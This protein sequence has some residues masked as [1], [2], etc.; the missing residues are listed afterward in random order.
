MFRMCVVLLV[1]S[2]ICTVVV[3]AP[4]A[5]TGYSGE[6]VDI[7]CTYE[8]G[9][10][11][12]PKYLCKDACIYGNRI[13]M[14]KSGSPAKDQRFSLSDDRTARV[15]TVTITELRTADAGQYWCGVEK[16][17]I[18]DVY[19]EI[20]LLVKQDNKTT[21]V[22][23][24]STFTATPSNFSTT[25]PYPQSSNI[26]VTERKETITE[27]KE[28]ITER[29]ETIPDRHNSSAG[30]V[31]YISVGV[32]IMLVI[33]LMA[34]MLLCMKRSRKSPR[35]TQSGLSQ[36]VSVVLLPLNEK[37]AED[38][39][40]H[41]YEEINKWQHK[42]KDITTVYTTADRLDDPTI[43]STA[44]KPDD[45]TIYSTADKPD[46]STIYSSADKPEDSTI[47]STA[48]KPDDSMIYSTADKPDVSTIYSTVD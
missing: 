6:R 5:V 4:V 32:V 25:E 31:I 39:N 1:F 30:S 23:T 14:V 42:N 41:K 13:I 36:Q 19:S 29:N 20:L 28:T 48:D 15:F 38:F 11:S 34:L 43:Y 18:D 24:I 40:D 7:R 2:S 44:D 21:E 37:T 47:Y 9:Y 27:R 45:P 35:V 8:S 33:F 26:T 46:D 3:G 16:T 22:S 17:V 12:N 10:E